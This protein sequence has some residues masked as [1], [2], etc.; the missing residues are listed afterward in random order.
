M[1]VTPNYGWPVPVATDFVKDG[2]EAIADLGDAI[3]ATVF[4]LPAAG[5]S[6]I[7]TTTFS[8]VASQSVNNVFTSSYANYRVLVDLVGSTDMDINCRLRTSGTDNSS[9]TYN[10]RRATF[11][12][13]YTTASSTTATLFYFAV[14]RATNKSAV[15]FDFFKP[16]LATQTSAL[17]QSYE[18][19]TLL[20]LHGL[21]FTNT[22]Q[23]DGFTL[24]PS[25]G[26]ITGQIKVYG[27]SD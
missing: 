15:S 23:F 4:G 19:A 21:T 2:Y 12:S 20:D 22:T 10:T 17:G 26:T 16:Q 18:P 7:N 25:T 1:A 24:L 27:Y 11:Q 8:A 3:D 5:L 13:T 9:A 14:G 6:L